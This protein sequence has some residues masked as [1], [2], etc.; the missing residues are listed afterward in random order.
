MS[1][2]R[3]RGETTS[4]LGFTASSPPLPPAGACGCTAVLLL[5]KCCCES[6]GGGRSDTT[7]P[8]PGADLPYGGTILPSASQ[9]LQ[10]IVSSSLFSFVL[11][12]FIPPREEGAQNSA[13]LPFVCDPRLLI[14][15]ILPRVRRLGTA[16]SLSLV[17]NSRAPMALLLSSFLFALLNSVELFPQIRGTPQRQFS[18]NLTLCLMSLLLIRIRMPRPGKAVGERSSSPAPGTSIGTRYRTCACTGMAAI[19][20]CRPSSSAA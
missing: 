14:L 10:Y 4:P 20:L 15:S 9:G 1:P 11:L 18:Q 7:S 13:E 12:F 3:C 8:L 16:L 6:G 2:L 19:P 17:E 5:L